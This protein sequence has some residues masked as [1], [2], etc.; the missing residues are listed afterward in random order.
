MPTLIK[1]N[2]EARDLPDLW[3]QA[4]GDLYKKGRRKE[5]N[6]GS[7]EKTQTRLEYDWFTGHVFN[8][9]FGSGTIQILPQIPPSFGI[10]D[11]VALDYVYGGEKFPRSYVEY[12]MTSA[13]EPGESYTYGQRLVEAPLTGEKAGW[14]KDKNKDIIDL[15]EVDGK[16]LVKKNGVIYLNQIEWV[17]DTYKKYGH[18]NN[19]M[20][21]EIAHPTDNVLLDPPC[22]RHIDTRIQ[23]SALHFFIYFRSWDLWSGLPA[24]LA[25]IQA[26]KEYM[27]GQIG[28]EDGEMIVYSKG[29]HIYGYAEKIAKIRCMIEDSS[30]VRDQT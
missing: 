4:L 27:A 28:V 20:I 12:V 13:K 22:L 23:D 2:I 8:P 11:P 24:N 9:G 18:G 19:Q 25:G 26:L 5:I 21:M 3:F 10:P 30:L 15:R 1:H 29:L 16:I 7:F 14:W 6:K 17:I